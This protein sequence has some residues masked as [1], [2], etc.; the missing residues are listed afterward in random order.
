ML[1]E[2]MLLIGLESDVRHNDVIK[3]VASLATA[4]DLLRPN[5]PILGDRGIPSFI[6]SSSENKK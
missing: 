4:P 5:K 1:F 2:G 3:R 6:K